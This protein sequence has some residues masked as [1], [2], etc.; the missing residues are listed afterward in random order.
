MVHRPRTA[1]LKASIQNE[2]AKWN[3]AHFMSQRAREG[4]LIVREGVHEG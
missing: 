3:S 4:V 1:T 2:M